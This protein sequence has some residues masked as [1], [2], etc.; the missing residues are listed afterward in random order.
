MLVALHSKSEGYY[1]L[2]F[3]GNLLNKWREIFILKTYLVKYFYDISLQLIEDKLKS[4]AKATFLW[5]KF[6]KTRI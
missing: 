3:P 4:K 1:F 6:G 5:K 2:K